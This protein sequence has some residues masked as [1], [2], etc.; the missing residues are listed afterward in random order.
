MNSFDKIQECINLNKNFVL[1]GGAGSGKTE[2]LKGTLEYVKN[3]FPT[4]KIVCI[5]HT[6]L[7]VAEIESRVS[8]GNYCISTIH[9]FLNSFIRN[10]K[11]NIHSVIA[12]LFLVDQVV[13]KIG[14]GGIEYRT[15]EF[16]NYKK[17][18][19][20]YS[21]QLFLISREVA[22]KQIGKREYDKNFEI[23]NKE[24]N[25]KINLLNEIIINDIQKRDYNIIEYNE[26]AFNSFRDLSYGHD[27]LIDVAYLLFKKYPI[28]GKILQDKF[29]YVFI[30]EYQDTN[31]KII[32]IFLNHL[33]KNTTTLVGLFGDSM[34]AIYQD[35]IGD[36][37]KYI[38]EKIVRIEKEDNYRCSSQVV[39]LINCLR[40]D[41]LVQK[42][43]LKKN[44]KDSD[45]QG[46][47]KIYYSIY[48]NKPNA[49]SA[50]DEKENYLK[51]LDELIQT[52][53][54]EFS[55][56]KI[57]MLTNKSV[58]QKAGFDQLYSVFAKRFQ[59]P[60]DY[61]EKTLRKLH[62]DDLVGILR[63]YKDKKYNEIFVSL[64]K[65]GISIKNIKD[66][67]SLEEKINK[68]IDSKESAFKT[69][70]MAFDLKLIKKS[71]SFESFLDQI[72]K[73]H[74]E[75]ANDPDYQKVKK[76]ILS[77]QGTFAKIR[78]SFPNIEEE[79]FD[80]CLKKFKKEEFFIDLFSES[81]PFQEIMKYFSYINE[82]TEFITMHKTKGTG[83]N[84]VIVVL[85]EYF[86]NE[87]KF[88]S[89]FESEVNNDI[90]FKNMKLMYVACSRAKYNLSCVRL[91]SPNEEAV[92]KKYFTNVIKI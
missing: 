55:D 56:S 14:D 84:N 60:K 58:S 10:F 52:A 57:L 65:S 41:G 2:T 22:A 21:S 64:K 46:E 8:S 92:I 88:N 39:E 91:V 89:I 66:K 90:R 1:Q 83:L 86:W 51:K 3:N 70:M 42:V 18:Y 37:N 33:P 59:E 77:G 81:I 32:E 16:E 61:I 23:I 69:L 34:Q 47:V 82:E 15:S 85:D 20:R 5:T 28:F 48:D 29:D 76:M 27:G 87:Y 11:Y 49:F 54:K 62:F 38:G 40:V 45:R 43:V 26:T 50:I 75:L 35:G 25:A 44:E 7:A 68:V 74:E 63:C 79:E 4:K 24:L 30:D 36:V 13:R 12:E 71:E 78:E 67:L 6:N 53:K 17:I 80:E 19:K 72:D 73:F 31:K 9:S